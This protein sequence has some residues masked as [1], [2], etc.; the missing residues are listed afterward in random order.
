MHSLLGGY[1]DAF[2]TSV[3]LSADGNVLSVGATYNTATQN[4]DSQELYLPNTLVYPHGSV[5]QF[6][7]TSSGWSVM[8]FN[9]GEVAGATYGYEYFGSS[10][11][12]SSDGRIQAA[13]APSAMNTPPPPYGDLGPKYYT[14]ICR[15]GMVRVYKR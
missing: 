11:A 1:N 12:L 7:R 9:S 4:I 10:V 15:G 5:R 6:T 3:A 13:S 8:S 14:G 2:G